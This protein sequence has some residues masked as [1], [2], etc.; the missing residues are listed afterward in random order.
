MIKL[1][2][3]EMDRSFTPTDPAERIKMTLQLCDMVKEHIKT[4]VLKTWGVNPGGHNGFG[5]SEK[6]EKEILA[7][8]S[9]YIPYV[10]F[11]VEAML[12]IEEVVAT[13]KAM[14]PKT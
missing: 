10:K 14:Q 4:G 3:W 7:M 2:T 12:S 5:I 6:D 11:T 13:L 9:M 8:A 1:I